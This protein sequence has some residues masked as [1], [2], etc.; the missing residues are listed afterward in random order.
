[1]CI[2]D[3]LGTPSAPGT[4]GLPTGFGCNLMF[5]SLNQ[6][7]SVPLPPADINGSL[8][9]PLAIHVALLG[10]T[11]GF[12]AVGLTGAFL[13]FSNGLSASVGW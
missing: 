11:F 10:Q 8:N 3:S 6:M 5:A 13:E 9:F 2:R 4:P 12:Q 1:M 7:T